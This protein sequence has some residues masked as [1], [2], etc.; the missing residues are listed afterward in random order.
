MTRTKRPAITL[1]IAEIPD[2]DH[3]YR[4]RDSVLEAILDTNLGAELLGTIVRDAWVSW[5][6]EQPR[7]KPGWLVP[8]S[9]LSHT[10][11]EAD[12]RIG[13]AVA[14]YV[15]ETLIRVSYPQGA[16]KP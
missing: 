15:V 3:I 5:A 13:L 4:M 1:P 9:E 11:Q 10:D 7:P 6:R 12:R 16:R 2:G 8:W 14:R